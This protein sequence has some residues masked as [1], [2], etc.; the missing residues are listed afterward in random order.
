[1]NNEEFN[2]KCRDIIK[3]AIELQEKAT[4]EGLLSLDDVI[5]REKAR[6]RDIFEYGLQF[7]TD[8]EDYEFVEKILSNIIRHEKD[9]NAALL[10]TMQKEAVLAIK[11]GMNHRLMYQ[12]LNSYTTM[13]LSDEF[14]EID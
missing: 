2:Q 14:M 7:V 10:K 13:P 11:C 4:R 1:M 5:D 9:E 8:G 3:R 6:N 12:L